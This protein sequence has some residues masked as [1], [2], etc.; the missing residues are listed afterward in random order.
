MISWH[1]EEF[2]SN[3]NKTAHCGTFCIRL[4]G[5]Q[6]IEFPALILMLSTGIALWPLGRNSMTQLSFLLNSSAGCRSQ[7][8]GFTWC[9]KLWSF[10]PE[11]HLGHF[12][13]SAIATIQGTEGGGRSSP[14]VPS[15][16]NLFIPVYCPDDD[17]EGHQMV[18]IIQNGITSAQQILLLLGKHLIQAAALFITLQRNLLYIRFRRHS[19][20]D[21][22]EKER[23]ERR[24][25]AANKRK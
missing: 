12:E 14:A 18:S 19:L 20:I 16:L 4:R 11:Q 7:L 5:V 22:L 17:F 10:S 2:L 3:K 13:T 15:L 6:G 23:G 25:V 21:T 9:R 8:H 24:E 1:G